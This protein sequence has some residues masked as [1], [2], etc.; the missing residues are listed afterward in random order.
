MWLFL[1]AEEGVQFDYQLRDLVG[2]ALFLDQVY[3]F[4]HASVLR[5]I[6]H[7]GLSYSEDR[8]SWARG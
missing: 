3:E 7:R 2:I 5:G 6:Q 8:L 4:F 1:L